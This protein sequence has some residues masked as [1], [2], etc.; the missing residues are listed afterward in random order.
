MTHS[1]PSSNKQKTH[2]PHVDYAW[3]RW[4]NNVMA[5]CNSYSVF[6]ILSAFCFSA[7]DVSADRLVADVLSQD[8]IMLALDDDLAGFDSSLLQN[9]RTDM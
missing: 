2:F 3:K 7:D 4:M 9:T 6:G 5:M 8:F 1:L